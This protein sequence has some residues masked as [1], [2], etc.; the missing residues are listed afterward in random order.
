[1]SKIGH[2][3]SETK[4]SSCFCDVCRQA[5]ISH[6]A[7]VEGIPYNKC[8]GCS[9]IYADESKFYENGS[10]NSRKYDESYW[11]FE[12]ESA[13]ERS[14]GSSLI[15]VAEVF[16]MACRP[17]RGFIDISSG[18]GALLDALSFLL[19]EIADVFYGNEP[20]PPPPPYR[21]KHKNYY[22]GYI[23]EIDR[24]FDG[25]VCI[26]VIEHLFPDTLRALLSR[27]AS[28]SNEGAL[29]YFNSAQPSFVIERDFGY[30]DPF[31]RGH[32]A[33]YS[34]A[35]AQQLFAEAGFSVYELPGR[36]WGFFAEYTPSIGRR[37]ETLDSLFNRLWNP[38]PEN[39][40]LLKSCKF[41]NFFL[42]AGREGA[43]CY[44]EAATAD[45]RTKWALSLDKEL[46]ERTE[47]ALS[48]DRALNGQHE[49]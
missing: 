33:S 17:I 8:E 46:K 37:T 35:G 12:V 10:S 21:S 4:K 6:F 44:L 14:Y 11:E 24:K 26:E 48:L 15:R 16:I 42:S 38:Q 31:E 34:V 25:G 19:P 36:D 13:K 2:Q 49:T 22:V 32:V 41:G 45:E 3:F 29:Y 27:L 30:L 43:R 7:D 5:S 28:R 20:F 18:G 47:W 39:L 23:E 9:S 1:M 40:E